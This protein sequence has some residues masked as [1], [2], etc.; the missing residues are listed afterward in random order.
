M[1]TT[2]DWKMS[3]R[4]STLPGLR[5][6]QLYGNIGASKKDVRITNQIQKQNKKKDYSWL[7]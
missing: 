5:L 4:S 6:L 1:K 2:K 7:S 3:A